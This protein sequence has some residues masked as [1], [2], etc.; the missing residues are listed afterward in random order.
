MDGSFLKKPILNLK[1]NIE[2]GASVK[3]RAQR[4][5]KERNKTL[6]YTLAD[7]SHEATDGRLRD[8]SYG[9]DHFSFSQ[10]WHILSTQP[11]P[12]GIMFK[13]HDLQTAALN[14]KS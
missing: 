6:G 4:Q 2:I 8:H 1:Q 3:G 5:P 9:I 11:S 10:P 7:C 14:P 12:M 13:A